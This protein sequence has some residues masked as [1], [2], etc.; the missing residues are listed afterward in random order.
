MPEK[1]GG[2]AKKS[3]RQ[4]LAR[5]KREQAIDKQI[6]R[7]Y[8]DVP[9]EVA[10]DEKPYDQGG[11]PRFAAS[12]HK[13]LAHDND[14]LLSET[15]NACSPDHRNS[16]VQNY[17]QLLKALGIGKP[18]SSDFDSEALNC[19]ELCNRTPPAD[20]PDPPRPRV[21]INPRSSKAFSIKGPDITSLRVS[22]LLY[23][24]ENEQQL[25]REISLASNES[26]AEIVEVYGMALLRE[27][28]LGGYA[29]AVA[30]SV[31]DALNAFGKAFVWGY[32]HQGKAITAADL[33][34]TAA[35]L[36]R[37][38]TPGDREG[39]YLSVFLTFPRPPLFPSGCAADVADLIGAGKFARVLSQPLRVPHGADRD[40]VRTRREYACVQNA[41][42]PEIYPKGHFHRLG[43]L[44]TGRH[45]GDYVHVDNVY[46]EYIRAADILV[47]NAYPRSPQSPYARLDKP[48]ADCRNN[49]K[50]PTYRNEA[51]GPTLGPSD[52]YSLLGGVREVAERAAFTQKWLVARRARP[53][54]MAALVDRARNAKTGDTIGLQIRE[55]LSGFLTAG[56][57]PVV[58]LLNSVA[59]FNKSRG[60]ER[61]FLLP[62]MYPEGSPA[63]PAWPSGHA[64][65]AGACVTVL[66]A[67]FDESA[68]IRDPNTKVK[69]ASGKTQGCQP[70]LDQQ[71]TP[72]NLGLTVGGELD[73]LASN[74][75]LGRDFGGVH[76]R[77]DG[78]HGILLG[79]EVAIRY[80]QD[81]LREYRETI[82]PCG[83][84]DHRGL[85]LTRRNGQPICITA[86]EIHNIEPVTIMTAAIDAAA[87][88]ATVLGYSPL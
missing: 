64:T 67:L 72:K 27:A 59:A 83:V 78:E 76:F 40:F 38:S 81:H 47:G 75:A 87:P 16:G 14:G 65:V 41:F 55:R 63:H 26:A 22:T 32:N 73:K 70:P 35:N 3:K 25:L 52:I 9:N 2:S 33:Q 20:P 60:G 71:A 31:I 30:K 74:V 48:P 57:G 44:V 45:L 4:K 68:P 66:K 82:R 54:V 37:G 1:G 8:Y 61:N 11:F 84:K 5:E 29:G 51:D 58:K 49:E 77:T 23:L 18:A 24:E 36:F 10:P 62:Q 21:L 43:P 15:P 28:T 46:E 34:V 88:V 19:L 56:S 53:E 39:A 79:E 80:L 85:T 12:F 42:V 13:L 17:E 7:R 6:E 50:R 69:A 86:D